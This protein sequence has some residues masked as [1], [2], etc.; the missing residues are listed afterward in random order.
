MAVHLESGTDVVIVNGTAAVDASSTVIAQFVEAYDEKYDWRYDAESYGPP[1]PV[2][3]TEVFAW[4]AAGA[5][6]RDGFR[7]SGKWTWS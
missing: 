2:T 7:A 3:P 6:G 1:T 5:A 4:Q